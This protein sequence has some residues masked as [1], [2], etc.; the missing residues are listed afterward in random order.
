MRTKDSGTTRAR[1]WCFTINNYDDECIA[2]LCSP[3]IGLICWVLLRYIIW[4]TEIGE[5]GTQHVQGYMEMHKRCRMNKIKDILRNDA[6]LEPANGTGRDNIRYCRKDADVADYKF[7]WG[8]PCQGGLPYTMVEMLEEGAKMLDVASEYPLEFIRHGKGME[9]LKAIHTDGNRGRPVVW[10][11][12]G[13]TG[14]G[15]TLSAREVYATGSDYYTVPWPTGGRWWW[16][17]YDGQRTI[18]LDEFPGE[19]EDGQETSYWEQPLEE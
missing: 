2:H 19:D 5:N 12:Y 18:I 16:P 7:E 10:I 11:L 3:G 9:A 13:S 15:K 14:S 8:N 17:G 4:E 6:H 1:R